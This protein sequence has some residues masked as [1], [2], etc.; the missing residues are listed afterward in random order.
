MAT[1]TDPVLQ[2]IALMLVVYPVALIL[3]GRPL[4]HLLS[5]DKGN[6]L[7]YSVAK[8][9]VLANSGYDFHGC[10]EHF[11]YL[12]PS[13]LE[14]ESWWQDLVFKIKNIYNSN[15]MELIDPVQMDLI[16]TT[17]CQSHVQACHMM[18]WI[19]Y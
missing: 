17:L 19:R 9:C 2:L 4:D 13:S 10:L 5:I 8:E 7:T 12:A 18:A 11:A 3:Q 15:K 16:I 14:T 6:E 1:K